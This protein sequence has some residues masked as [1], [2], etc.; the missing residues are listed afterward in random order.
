[1]R[2]TGLA[3]LPLH[4]GKCPKWLFQR[5]TALARALVQ[6]I[7]HEYGAEELLRR[8]SDPI[9]FQS[10]GC[11]L[12]F[13][14]HSSGLTTSVCGALKEGIRGIETELGFFI[15]GGKG[16]TSL[17]TPEEIERWASRVRLAK[18]PADLVYASRLSAKVDNTALQDGYQLYHHAFIFTPNGR[19]AVVQQGMNT[20]SRRAR[21]YHWLSD[22][23]KDFVDEPHSG[24]ISE[25]KEKTPLDMTAHQSSQA[26]E[27]SAE[28][29]KEKPKKTIKTVEHLK[30]LRLPTRHEIFIKDLKPD[31]LNRILLK[32]YEQQ[33]HN[34]EQLLGIRGVGP[35]TI[36]ALA[37]I[38]ELVYGAKPSYTD[39]VRYSF[40]HGGKDGHPYPVNREQYDKSIEVLRKAVNQAKIGRTEKLDAIKRLTLGKETDV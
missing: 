23:V 38:S 35:K 6:T 14:W 15:A 19:W 30:E 28:V 27:V 18:N 36:R 3:E 8:L 40:A 22:E 17:K 34:F 32:T 37:L 13:D 12:S 33:P 2:R 20:D 11:A 4:Y 10:L 21:R 29:A 1:M 9:F 7:V 24:I 25:H 31:T 16:K 26:R 39:P 5:M